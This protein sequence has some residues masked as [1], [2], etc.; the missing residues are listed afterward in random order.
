MKSFRSFPV[1]ILT[2]FLFLGILFY[3]FKKKNALYS[4]R[5]CLAIRPSISTLVSAR[6]NCFS[7]FRDF[8]FGGGVLCEKICRAS[9]SFRENGI[10]G[11][12]TSPEGRHWISTHALHVCSPIRIN[13][14]I[15]APRSVIKH[16]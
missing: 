11:S 2:R 3:Y 14:D 16:P 10:S 15:V 7:N 9:V 13:S 5:V 4:D 8:F 12:F 6:L 1:L